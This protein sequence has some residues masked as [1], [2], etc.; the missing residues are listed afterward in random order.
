[1]LALLGGLGGVVVAQDEEAAPAELP[2]GPAQFT[3]VEDDG[4]NVVATD[5]RMSGE[6]VEGDWVTH[7]MSPTGEVYTIPL[8]IENEAGVWQGTSAG[9]Q[10]GYESW[11]QVWLVGEGA[12]D[13]LSAVFVTHWDY[14]SSPKK[15]EQNG[16]IFEGDV[17]HLGLPAE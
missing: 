12:Y 15:G 8:H 16:L 11:E 1:M 6:W 4:L 2:T 5:P 9:H 13:G 10:V 7:S 14:S 3:I 17:P